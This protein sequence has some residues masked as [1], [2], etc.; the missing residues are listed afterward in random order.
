MFAV[1]INLNAKAFLHA[2]E[3]PGVIALGYAGQFI[4]KPI[5]GILMAYFA[6]SILHLPSAIGTLSSRARVSPFH[7][8]S[9]TLSGR[10]PA[11]FSKFPNSIQYQYQAF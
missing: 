3:R 6:V 1:G 4:V 9:C 2:M 10:S 5:L 8:L 11:I 7:T